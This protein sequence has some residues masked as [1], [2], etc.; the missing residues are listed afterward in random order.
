MHSRKYCNVACG[1][2]KILACV[3]ARLPR[4]VVHGVY[5]TT[6][7]LPFSSQSVC[8]GVPRAVQCVTCTDVHS[9]LGNNSFRTKMIIYCPLTPQ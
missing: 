7:G 2:M 4:M 1:S 9:S 5:L 6:A 8:I 3:T